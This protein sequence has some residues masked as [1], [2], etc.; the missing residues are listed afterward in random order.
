MIFSIDKT[1]NLLNIHYAFLSMAWQMLNLFAMVFLYKVGVPLPFVFLTIAGIF[2]FRFSFRPLALNLIHKI[3]CKKT[4]IM[5]TMLS[6]VPAIVITEVKEINQWL[7]WYIVTSAIADCFY[8]L[9]YHTF[10][11]NSGSLE[12]RGSS[13]GAREGLSKLA[14]I[15]GPFISGS[16]LAI[17]GPLAAFGLAAFLYFLASIPLFLI[18]NFEIKPI[19][20]KQK[21]AVSKFGMKIFVVWGFMQIVTAWPIIL[22]KLFDE[23]FGIYGG[24][25]SLLGFFMAMGSFI[26]GKFIDQGKGKNIY[27]IAILLLVLVNLGRAFWVYD[28]TGVIIFDILYSIAICFFTPVSMTAIYN[29]SKISQNPLYFQYYAEVGW[30]WGAILAMLSC[31][32]MAFLAIDLRYSLVLSAIGA[33]MTGVGLYYYYEKR[34]K[35]TGMNAND[36]EKI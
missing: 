2:L 28:L 31:A 30:D 3:G 36:L 34:P 32:G 4:L 11:A 5:G 17:A 29:L 13:L 19:D 6:C 1:V 12:N 27:R 15:V 35:E 16:L 21:K 24:L 8:W 22:F 23:S 10:F 14:L 18:P 7:F 33:V 25:L 20:R 9:S 26:L